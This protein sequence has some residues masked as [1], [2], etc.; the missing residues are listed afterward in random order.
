MNESTPL[1]SIIIPTY[2][3]A[4]L[5]PRAI[6]SVLAQ[7][8][9][10]FELIVVDDMSMDNTAATVK[11]FNDPRIRYLHRTKNGS[12]A[13]SRNTGI[14]S[15]KGTYIAFLDDDDEYLPEFLERTAQVLENTPIS[16]A[17]T[18]CGTLTVKDTPNGEVQ[19]SKGLWQP[20]FTDR[21]SAYCSFL[22]SRRIGTNCGITVRSQA[23]Q[24]IGLFDETLRKAEDTDFLIRMVRCFEF[25]VVPAHLVKIHVHSGPQLTVYDQSMANAYARII[26]KNI[27]TL[28][29]HPP[30][31]TALHYK[32]GWLYY[33]G[34][35]KQKAR[36]YIRRALRRNPL[37]LKS[38]SALLTHELLGRKAAHLH[39][40]LSLLRQKWWQI[41]EATYK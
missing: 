26:G 21:E 27:D 10:N 13:A 41:P 24:E 3:R 35:N 4:H 25:T 23:F 34:G 28:R 20:Q 38:W 17:L 19:I 15:A 39:S 5:L 2:N 36:T 37:H 40:K 14:K 29:K 22:V 11:G 9:T 8:F 32:T 16:T 30:I 6:K 1:F 31:W 18:W 7:T 12:A 33:H